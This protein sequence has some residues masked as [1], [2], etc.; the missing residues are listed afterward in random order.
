MTIE[1]NGHSVPRLARLA[2]VL[3]TCGA[4]SGHHARSV[5][6]VPTSVYTL[7]M[8]LVEYAGG[9]DTDAESV[10]HGT[11]MYLKCCLALSGNLTTKVV[12]SPA[13]QYDVAAGS[14]GIR[15]SW[16]ARADRFDH[17]LRQS[18]GALDVGFVLRSLF[19]RGS[20]DAQDTTR[21]SDY[22]VLFV[23]L[24]RLVE[25]HFLLVQFFICSVA[26]CL[27][28][29]YIPRG[30]APGMLGNAL[31]ICD[32]IRLGCYFCMLVALALYRRY[33]TICLHMRKVFLHRSDLLEDFTARNIISDTAVPTGGL[34]GAILFPVAGFL[35]GVVPGLVAIFSHLWTDEPFRLVS[36]GRRTVP[37][38]SDHEILQV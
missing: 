2:D 28:T 38:N 14:G 26:S 27:Y 22:V 36:L 4:L 24:R 29:W 6:Q 32:W 19:K 1:H 7:P 35:F 25:S 21:C 33:H 15:A 10:Q 23:V 37:T 17:G 18:W 3:R 30:L 5:V 34:A 13:V 11:H 31:S 20:T 12:Y 16:A 9:W 8:A